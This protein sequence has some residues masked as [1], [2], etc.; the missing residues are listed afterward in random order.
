MTDVSLRKTLIVLVPS[1]K[2]REIFMSQSIANLLHSFITSD[3]HWKIRLI[4][5]WP[6]IAGTMHTYTAIETI[7]NDS[8]TISVEN[9]CLMQELYHLSPLILS[10]INLTL[11]QP[12]I[13]NV[14]FK[15]QNNKKSMFKSKRVQEEVVYKKI[16]PLSIKE[17]K[18]IS[19][20]ADPELKNALLL[21]RKRCY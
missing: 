16:P 2:V 10:K 11:D 9:S 14:R 17:Q 7:S 4:K 6:D 15:L 20:I 12:R 19:S 13:K 21:F 18:A 5:Q 1:Y 3:A 8:I